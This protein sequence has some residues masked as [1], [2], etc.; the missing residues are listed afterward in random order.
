M[1]DEKFI[2]FSYLQSFPKDRPYLLSLTV[3][4][5]DCISLELMEVARIEYQILN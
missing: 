4:N 3:L 2:S 5:F 1:F